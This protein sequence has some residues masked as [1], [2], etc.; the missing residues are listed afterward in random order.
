MVSAKVLEK[1]SVRAWDWVWARALARALAKVLGRAWDWA[2]ESESAWAKVWVS[3]L[4]WASALAL[5]WNRRFQIPLLARASA[6][7]WVP[8][9]VRALAPV[10]P[11]EFPRAPRWVLRVRL[12]R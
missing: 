9:S 1:V 10:F 3:V 7:A 11:R 4:E 2:S 12:G 6:L 8:V 5:E